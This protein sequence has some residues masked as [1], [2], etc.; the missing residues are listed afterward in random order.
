MDYNQLKRRQPADRENCPTNLS[1]WIYLALSWSHREES[2]NSYLNGQF[3]FLWISFNTAYTQELECL[4]LRDAA[5]FS[6]FVCKIYNFDQNKGLTKLVSDIYPRS[7]QLLV[8]NQYVFQSFWDH[9]NGHDNTDNWHEKFDKAKLTL[10][11]HYPVS[12]SHRGNSRNF[13]L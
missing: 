2:F 10:V 8:D 3:I 1:L 4:N 12:T 6:Q 7:I 5:A 9:Q 13:L 11:N